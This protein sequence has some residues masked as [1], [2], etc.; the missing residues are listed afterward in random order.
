MT[1][2]PC[3]FVLFSY[4][5]ARP[6]LRKQRST[7][8]KRAR[9][10]ESKVI[11]DETEATNA[12]INDW[13]LVLL[14]GTRIVQAWICALLIYSRWW[15]T[16][17]YLLACWSRDLHEAP[18]TLLSLSIIITTIRMSLQCFH[19][20]IWLMSNLIFGCSED[21]KALRLKNAREGGGVTLEESHFHKCTLIYSGITNNLRS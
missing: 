15:F 3:H 4:T 21:N 17:G 2:Q 20:H 9:A 10:Y 7:L 19:S 14:S 16:W 11:E 1:T 13:L 18:P 12:I 6:T 5:A 8:M